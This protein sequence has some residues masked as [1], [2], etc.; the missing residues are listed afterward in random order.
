MSA[1]QAASSAELAEAAASAEQAARS[2]RKD[3]IRLKTSDIWN[4]QLLVMASDLF[5]AER[6]EWAVV[7]KNKI[8]FK[9]CTLL[10][11]I[12]GTELRNGDR[13]QRVEL[14]FID[15]DWHARIYRHKHDKSLPVVLDFR[16]A[17]GARRTGTAI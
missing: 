4:R 16:M 13:V 5:D 8:V 10:K 11:D 17:W 3:A 1:E 9:N 6:I 7:L 15:D 14:K 12:D 2:A